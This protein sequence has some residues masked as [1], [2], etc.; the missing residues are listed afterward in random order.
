MR[1][2]ATIFFA[3]CAI[4]NV[5]YSQNVGIGNTVPGARLDVAAADS[6]LVILHNTQLSLDS[7]KTMMYF[8]TGGY[9]TGAIGTHVTDGTEGAPY[10]RMGFFTFGTPDAFLLREHMSISDDGFVGINNV[11]P[12]AT[13]DVNGSFRLRNNGMA[14]GKVLTSDALG[15]A[16]WQTPVGFTVPYTG[17]APGSSSNIFN[18]TSSGT[19][20]TGAAIYGATASTAPAAATGGVA[21]VTGEVL[22]ITP[23]GFSAGVRGINRGTGGTGVGVLGYQAGTGYGVYGYSAAGTGTVGGSSTGVGGHFISTSG[24]A[25]YTI[26]GLKLTNINEGAGKVLTSD[27]AGNAT[28]QAPITDTKISFNAYLTTT[29]AISGGIFT[30]TGFTK[31]FEEGGNNLNASTGIYTVPSAGTYLFKSRCS[32]SP[33]SGTGNIS[34][35]SRINIA[36]AGGGSHGEQGN[37]V[38]PI[39]AGYSTSVE[40]SM[41][42][43]CNAGDQVYIEASHSSLSQVSFN[44]GSSTAATNFSGVRLF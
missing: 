13:L 41:I 7:V 5:S 29:T 23:G 6:G 33:G 3:L 42:Y 11:K 32:F 24:N 38:A 27:A 37:I 17:S 14:N 34:Y 8:K 30:V 28:W 19:A 44:G 15:Y 10:A 35:L 21:G 26:G 36:F 25:L 16:T 20:G 2:I 39:L 4:S 1:K 9:Y 31:R 18:I 12:A 40:C 22:S 43:K